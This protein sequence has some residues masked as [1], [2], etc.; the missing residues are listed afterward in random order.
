MHFKRCIHLSAL[1]VLLKIKCHKYWPELNQTFEFTWASTKPIPARIGTSTAITGPPKRYQLR[2]ATVREDVS[3][4]VAFREFYLERIT[5]TASPD[6]PA[7]PSYSVTR[8]RVING[9]AMRGD[10]ETRRLTQLQYIS[11]PDHGVPGD[12]GELIE[13]V[14]RMRRLQRG[15]S[16]DVSA[17]VP[18]AVVHCSAG[19]GRTGVLILLDTAM[20]MIRSGCPM[21]PVEMVRQMRN[22]REM[23][24]Q[25]PVR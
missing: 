6:T 20:D 19:I 23:L 18:P 5:S 1:I 4:D 24:I 7:F 25:T 13:F 10:G 17:R 21:N 16:S 8:P 9:V 2:V 11:W 12:C 15:S 22:Y 14:K 3:E